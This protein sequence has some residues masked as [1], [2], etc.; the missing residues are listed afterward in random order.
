[1]APD[2]YG[3]MTKNLWTSPIELVKHTTYK[4]VEVK[5][6]FIPITRE[7]KRRVKKVYMMEEVAHMMEV[8]AHNEREH[9]R[10]A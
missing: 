4:A 9:D 8:R 1:M 6:V 2:P 7:M 3:F 5:P 10:K